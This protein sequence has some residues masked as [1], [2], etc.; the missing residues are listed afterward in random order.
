MERLHLSNYCNKLCTLGTIRTCKNYN[1]FYD[2]KLKIW[3]CKNM[4]CKV[5][6]TISEVCVCIKCDYC[7][8]HV[9]LEILRMMSLS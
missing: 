6:R 8:I 1:S 4:F 2:V 7:N 3:N 5:F 9:M